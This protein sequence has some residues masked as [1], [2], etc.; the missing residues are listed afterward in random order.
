MQPRLLLLATILAAGLAWPS[1]GA[2]RA[3]SPTAEPSGQK[4]KPAHQKGKGQ[5][6]Q[7]RFRGLDRNNDGVITRDEWRGNDRSFRNHD[8]N[9]DGVLSATEVSHADDE[10]W[11]M[12]EDRWTHRDD[13]DE[14]L[15]EIFARADANGDRVISRREWYGDPDTFARID[16]DRNGVITL[17]EFLGVDASA[18]G[19]SGRAPNIA[20]P[21]YRTGYD[22]G[23]L[24]GR[25]AGREDRELRNQWDLEGQRELETADAGYQASMGAREDYQAGYRAGFR[26]GYRQGFG[27]RR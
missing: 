3:S 15:R 21:T 1:A 22:R 6:R 9:N 26:T 24:D 18:T 23:L 27:P 10:R 2:A 12:R 11:S 4:D 17:P 7:M 25:Q 16:Q 13:P 8:V 19:T 20:S 5:Q 14:E